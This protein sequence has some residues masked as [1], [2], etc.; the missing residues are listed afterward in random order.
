MGR[1]L[2]DLQQRKMSR[3]QV[4][5]INVPVSP[6][7]GEPSIKKS[8]KVPPLKIR[9][10]PADQVYS[11]SKTYLKPRT[12]KPIILK[13]PALPVELTDLRL[14][15]KVSSIR[16]PV[17][18]WAKPLLSSACPMQLT[19]S[20]DEVADVLIIDEDVD[21]EIYQS[22]GCTPITLD[23]RSRPHSPTVRYT[24]KEASTTTK[25]DK[26]K[27]SPEQTGWNEYS[28]AK[29]STTTKGE[30]EK[31]SPELTDWNQYSHAK[32]STTK[33]EKEKKSPELTDWNQYSH[34]KASTTTE[35]KEKKS[36]EQTGWDRYVS[37]K[38]SK[39]VEEKEPPKQVGLD[40]SIKTCTGK[41]QEEGRK[42]PVQPVQVT[43]KTPPAPPSSPADISP[44]LQL[45]RDAADPLNYYATRARP[46][47]AP[48]ARL[49]KPDLTNSLQ[50]LEELAKMPR[51]EETPTVQKLHEATNSA[52]GRITDQI[53]SLSAQLKS[54]QQQPNNSNN[55]SN[56]QHA[57]K[58]PSF[59]S[60]FIPSMSHPTL[61]TK[62]E[63]ITTP[64]AW[65]S[66]SA[67]SATATSTWPGL[68]T[69]L[70]TS[71]GWSPQQLVPPPHQKKGI[72]MDHSR[73]LWDNIQQDRILQANHSG[74]TGLS[75]PQ[76]FEKQYEIAPELKA[77]GRNHHLASWTLSLQETRRADVIYSFTVRLMA[78]LFE[79]LRKSPDFGHLQGLDNL[80]WN[81]QK[82]FLARVLQPFMK[83]RSLA[84]F[85]SFFTDKFGKDDHL[86]KTMFEIWAQFQ[87][88]KIS[89]PFCPTSTEQT[90]YQPN[91]TEALLKFPTNTTNMEND[92]FPPLPALPA[93]HKLWNSLT[94]RLECGRTP[95]EA[96]A[97][98]TW[99][100]IHDQHLGRALVAP[101]FELGHFTHTWAFTF[102][103]HHI[104]MAP[105]SPQIDTPQIVRILRICAMF[106]ASKVIQVTLTNRYPMGVNTTGQV[107]L[108]LSTGEASR[109]ML[110][111]DL[112]LNKE[113]I[114][115]TGWTDASW[116][117]LFGSQ[118]K[119]NTF[120]DQLTAM[121]TG[122][123]F[124]LSR[125]LAGL[126][127]TS[128]HDLRPN[129]DITAAHHYMV[130]REK[131]WET[132]L[133][134]H[135]PLN[136]SES[137]FSQ[138]VPSQALFWLK[139][140]K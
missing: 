83:V 48:P 120:Y 127:P 81:V 126:S 99:V 63:K 66:S 70:P 44:T 29:A 114:Q 33:G 98:L 65:A 36:P 121:K 109:Q 105:A 55:N 32:A 47:P 80:D 122:S 15:K 41:D 6:E 39:K 115:S 74:P 22:D 42:R 67:P 113:H 60:D 46:A 130:A 28:Q 85:V 72:L 25:G 89:H 5:P 62:P 78:T 128:W 69:T 107:F 4:S 140:A 45:L 11:S 95:V 17:N 134:S 112:L 37:A 110:A 34:A 133:L 111:S 117:N 52:F 106:I 27:T 103:P 68:P 61:W 93:R 10:K 77:F 88:S 9:I 19:V 135:A 139:D 35:E 13:E 101:L 91:I 116:T 97:F 125:P 123:L 3:G 90:Q 40:L 51:A 108:P 56:Y 138:I 54:I 31:K 82:T 23:A 18:A 50:R 21:D 8:R 96:I 104:C 92:Y 124:H 2:K 75:L 119:I 86:T 64:P 20:D 16:K 71:S 136:F 1:K 7:D 84:G 100:S 49:T 57:D 53:Q 12:K 59:A 58:F 118:E 131:F 129:K 102:E 79:A 26:K 38:A 137:R 94:H 30:K 87:L 76:M 73:A 43:F 24:S 14:S 132:H